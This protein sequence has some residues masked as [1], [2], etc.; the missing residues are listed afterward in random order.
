MFRAE[1]RNIIL[2]SI[3][4]QSLFNR[5]ANAHQ[6][7]IKRLSNALQTLIKRSSNTYQTLIKRSSSFGSSTPF[8]SLLGLSSVRC[9]ATPRTARAH[10]L[11]CGISYGRHPPARHHGAPCFFSRQRT[12][13]LRHCPEQVGCAA[14]AG[15]AIGSGGHCASL[16]TQ[17]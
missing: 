7:L 13:C 17:Y 1:A 10:T 11:M 15:P 16:P 4:F 2:S 6:T 5:S 3:A 9:A 8:P 14:A 12:G